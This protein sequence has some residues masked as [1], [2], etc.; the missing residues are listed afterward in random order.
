MRWDVVWQGCGFRAAE[1]AF[2]GWNDGRTCERNAP[3]AGLGTLGSW[4]EN[5]ELVLL[6]SLP[7]YV[8]YLHVEGNS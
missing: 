4:Q 8:I 1:C 3:W 5:G 2:E 7:H 6:C